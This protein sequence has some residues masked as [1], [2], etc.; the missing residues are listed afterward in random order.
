MSQ[1]SHV[2]FLSLSFKLDFNSFDNYRLIKMFI[3]MNIKS[4][5]AVIIHYV[6]HFFVEMRIIYLFGV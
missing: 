6:F 2:T 4:K 1:L 5:I 3:F